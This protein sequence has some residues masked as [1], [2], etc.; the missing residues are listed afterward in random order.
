MNISVDSQTI[1]AHTLIKS[2]TITLTA[3]E[4]QLL[5]SL[6]N[7]IGGSPY[8]E[9]NPAMNEGMFAEIYIETSRLPKNSQRKIRSLVNDLDTALL[10]HDFLTP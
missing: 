10:Q 1:P 5:K 7:N 2:V 4:A 3:D 9:D 6:V 8:Y